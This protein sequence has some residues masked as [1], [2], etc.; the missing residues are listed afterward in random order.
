MKEKKTEKVNE[1]IGASIVYSITALMWLIVMA[2]SFK[3][4]D[5]DILKLSD[6]ERISYGL[7]FLIPFELIVELNIFDIDMAEL[8]SKLRR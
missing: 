3:V 5:V 7:T 2:I 4:N 1:M 8:A 6:A